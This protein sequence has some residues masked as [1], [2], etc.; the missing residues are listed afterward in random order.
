MEVFELIFNVILRGL[1]YFGLLHLLDKSGVFI[2]RYV[3]PKSWQR[4]IGN[5]S[6][7][8]HG[9]ALFSWIAIVSIFICLGIQ[10]TEFIQIDSCLDSGNNWD[11][12]NDVCNN[13]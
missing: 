4:K 11:Y 2:H 12:D 10:I 5:N 9:I 8:M 13:T 7:W 1:A 6:D 3:F